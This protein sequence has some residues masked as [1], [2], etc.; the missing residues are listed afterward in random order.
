MPSKKDALLEAILATAAMDDDEEEKNDSDQEATVAS[1]GA[2]NSTIKAIRAEA[3]RAEKRAAAAEAEA[4]E[5]RTFREETLA[6]QRE[7]QL[8]AAGLTKAQAEVFTKAF[9]EVNEEN[10]RRFKSEVLG[11]SE[12]PGDDGERVPVGT[13]APATFPSEKPLDIVEGR[14][15]VRAYVAQHG[16]EAAQKAWAEGKLKL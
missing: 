5:L 2:E 3:K 16:I 11:L 1:G 13:F 10:V 6:R 12:Q 4:A 8:S 9:E 14:E 15:N 7:E